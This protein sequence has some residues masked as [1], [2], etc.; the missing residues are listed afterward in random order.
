[1]KFQNYIVEKT[2]QDE[3]DKENVLKY[4]ITEYLN[5]EIASEDS[6]E[7]FAKENKI[8]ITELYYKIAEILN[9]FLYRKKSNIEIDRD[10]LEKGIEHEYEHFDSKKNSNRD[11]AKIIAMDHLKEI[12]NYYDKLETIEKD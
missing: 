6:L 10:Q 4:K 9:Q 5:K 7:R 11:I 3:I 12:P 1:M 8:S 2:N